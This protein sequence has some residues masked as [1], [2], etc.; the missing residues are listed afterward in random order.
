MKKYRAQKNGEWVEFTL[1]ELVTL[2]AQEYSSFT[3]WQQ[4]VHGHW[5]DEKHTFPERNEK[6]STPKINA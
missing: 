4:N 6:E 5:V 1:G 3:N 2:S